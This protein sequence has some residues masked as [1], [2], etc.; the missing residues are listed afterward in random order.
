MHGPLSLVVSNLWRQY[1]AIPS[2]RQAASN[3]QAGGNNLS[4]AFPKA[5]VAGST[6]FANIVVFANVTPAMP[7]G[8]V[9]LDSNVASATQYVYYY[10]KAPSITGVTA[11]FTTPFPALQCIQIAE[12]PGVAGLDKLAAVATGTSASPATNAVVPAANEELVI[13]FFAAQTSS[14][15]FG[16]TPTLSTPT[17]GFALEVQSGI[18]Q[19]SGKPQVG[20][21]GG[22]SDITQK[23]AASIST[24]ATLSLSSN[25]SAIIA[26]FFP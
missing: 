23:I 18:N 15:S 5:T 1:N 14:L 12:Y 20:I 26:S 21:A 6:L 11:V 13:A 25:W 2:F 19:T 10:P 8:W 7:A 3:Q 4:A 16:S 17:N 24:G 22:I 9:L